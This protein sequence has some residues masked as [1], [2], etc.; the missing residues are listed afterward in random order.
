MNKIAIL[1]SQLFRKG[2]A[3]K[4]AKRIAE[5]FTKKNCEVHLIT[6]G[7]VELL[8]DNSSLRVHSYPF[9]KTFSFLHIKSFDTFCTQELEKISPSLILGLDRNRFQTHLRASNGVHAAYLKRRQVQDSF[10]KKITI[11]LNPLHRTLLKI[12]KESFE[13]PDLKLLI[14]NSHM[15]RQEIL[16][17]YSVDPKKIQVIHNGVE[18][19]EMQEDFLNW[20][21]AKRTAVHVF[22]LP[23]SCFHFLFIG[24][25]FR[26]KGLEIILRG[27]SLL[28]AHDFHLSVV[29]KEKNLFYFQKL[30]SEL[31]LQRKVSFFGSQPSARPFYQLAD[32]LVIPSFYDPFANVTVEALSMGVFAISSK[33]NGGSEVI[34]PNCGALLP[35]LTSAESVAEILLKAMQHP[36][37]KEKA[38]NIRSSVKHLDFSN[39][40]NILI[41]NCLHS[42]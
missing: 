2:G 29:G 13:H 24:H 20:E 27:L 34:Q 7:P 28:S 40:L 11:P 16:E 9:T 36:K 17:H 1:K 32:A 26:R 35:S 4:Y 22:N 18:W 38:D 42:L 30:C 8:A 3:E 39:Q 37:T 33:A 41:E 12:E 10:F 19:T 6:S 25:N 21:E 31:G 14:T 5:A 23:S 15:V